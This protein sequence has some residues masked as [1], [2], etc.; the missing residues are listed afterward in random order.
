MSIKN[1]IKCEKNNKKYPLTQVFH[2]NKNL[3]IECIMPNKTNTT[4]SL[5]NRTESFYS[6]ASFFQSLYFLRHRDN[7]AR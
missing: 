2:V 6:I 3:E 5:K 7:S 4:F 1:K